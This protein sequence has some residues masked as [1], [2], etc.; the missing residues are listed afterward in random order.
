M[1]EVVTTPDGT[2]FLDDGKPVTVR[3]LCYEMLTRTLPDDAAL[4]AA[5]A[6]R[7]SKAASGVLAGDLSVDQRAL[8]LRRL[9]AFPFT[10]M[11]KAA[12]FERLDPVAFSR[13]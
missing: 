1:D 9:D 12:L 6:A 7:M 4:P 2:P 5:E 10:P 13:A 8:L 11:V 3:A